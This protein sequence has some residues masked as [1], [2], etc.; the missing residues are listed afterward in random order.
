MS[1]RFK[2]RA[3]CSSRSCEYIHKEDIVQALNYETSYGIAE[4]LNEADSKP[5][6]PACGEEISY[7]AHTVIDE[8]WLP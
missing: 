7:Y 1:S 5:S 2:V 8:P 4:M 6:C 3:Y